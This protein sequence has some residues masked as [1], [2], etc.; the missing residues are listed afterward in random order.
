MGISQVD[1]AET[2]DGNADSPQFDTFGK[3]LFA[4]PFQRRMPFSDFLPSLVQQSLKGFQDDPIQ[5]DNLRDE[6]LPLLGDVKPSIEWVDKAFEGEDNLDA[7]N[8]WIGTSQSVTALHRDT[9]ENIYCQIVGSKHFVLL[10]PIATPCVNEQFL[11]P[12][13]YDKNMNLVRDDDVS[14]GSPSERE[15]PCALWDPDDPAKNATAATRY[16][17]PLRVTLEPGDMMY[18]PTCW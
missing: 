4:K 12:A 18:L 11:K 3:M 8:V 17:E 6:Y 2:P 10:P 13:T 16:C 7:V 14:E 1:I 9:Y 5:N 15:V